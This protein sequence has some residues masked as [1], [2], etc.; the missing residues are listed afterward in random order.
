MEGLAAGTPSWLIFV[1]GHSGNGEEGGVGVERG[2]G[3]ATLEAV[4]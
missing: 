2:S 1:K 4:Q 3:E